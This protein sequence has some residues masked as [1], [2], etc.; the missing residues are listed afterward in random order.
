M[1]KN[2]IGLFNRKTGKWLPWEG[3]R[4]WKLTPYNTDGNPEAYRQWLALS[5]KNSAI[6]LRRIPR[7]DLKAMGA[8]E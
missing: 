5:D 2:N 1:S 4:L 7:Q 8:D 6:E 3:E